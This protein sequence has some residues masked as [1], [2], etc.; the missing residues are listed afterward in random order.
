[1]GLLSKLL[2]G[3]SNFTVWDG[4]TPAIN[5]L[6]T[7]QSPLHAK[8]DQPGY[9]LDGSDASAVI[10]AYGEYIDGVL[11]AIPQPSQLDLNGKTPS[12]YSNNLPEGGINDRALDITG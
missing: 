4:S 9:S 7:K 5:P 2:T 8:N 12:K 11:N 6:S 3:G 10:T 1:M